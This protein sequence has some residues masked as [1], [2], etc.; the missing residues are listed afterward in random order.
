MSFTRRAFVAGLLLAAV[1]PFRPASAASGAEAYVSSVGNSVLAAARAKS[2]AKF[3]SLLR[4]N[5]DIRAIALFSLGAY[6]KNLKKAQESEY[7]SLVEAYISS[8]FAQ[9]AAKLAGEDLTI[10]SSKDVGDSVLVKSKLQ[11]AGGRSVPVTWRVVKRG[12]GYKIFDVNVDGIWL[13]TTQKTNFVSVLKKS[14]G[15]IDALL[16][17]LRG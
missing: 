15:D 5:A 6:R 1:T 13:A 8:V 11:Y 12:G 4:A 17:Y 9:N 3:R 2:V 7:V 16:A 14:N 10:V